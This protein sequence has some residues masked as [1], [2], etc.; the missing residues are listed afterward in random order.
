MIRPVYDIWISAY[1]Y[2]IHKS[3]GSEADTVIVYLPKSKA[4]M[5][6]RSLLYTAVTRAKKKVIIVETE[7]ALETCVKTID[8]D[9]RT[10]ML[11]LIVDFWKQSGKKKCA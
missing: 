2:T 5:M 10:K 8:A 4:H 3:Q 1:S 9:R 7:D 6:T 11:G